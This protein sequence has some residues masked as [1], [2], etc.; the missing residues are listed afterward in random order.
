MF[1]KMSWKITNIGSDNNISTWKSANGNK[2]VAAYFKHLCFHHLC[3]HR[4]AVL[5]RLTNTDA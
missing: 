4:K 2:M 5:Q 3:F 1:C